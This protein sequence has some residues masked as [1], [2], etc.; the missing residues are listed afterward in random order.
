[1][2]TK[3]GD[4]H[5][6]TGKTG[7]IKNEGKREEGEG[8]GKARTIFRSVP[9]G[10]QLFKGQCCGQ[11]SPVL[12]TN[13]YAASPF[14]HQ[15]RMDNFI[16]QHARQELS[17]SSPMWLRWC[18]FQRK[19]KQPFI[20]QHEHNKTEAS[21]TITKKKSMRKSETKCAGH[22]HKTMHTLFLE[23]PSLILEIHMRSERGLGV[24]SEVQMENYC[25]GRLQ[26]IWPLNYS[27][28][29]LSLHILSPLKSSSHL[30]A[31]ERGRVN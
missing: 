8:W 18:I 27:P 17:G 23:S 11:G 28:P 13:R 5:V 2:R 12:I 22:M 1:M 7:R 10:L 14:E 4:R 30:L 9:R 21:T 29:S 19:W 16:H 3:E 26:S 31:E 24:G 6:R 15:S 25:H 20:H